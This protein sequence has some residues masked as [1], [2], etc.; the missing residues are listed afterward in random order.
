MGHS[1]RGYITFNRASNLSLKQRQ[2]SGCDLERYR[3]TFDR[4]PQR[5]IEHQRRLCAWLSSKNIR[6]HLWFEQ[7]LT[8]LIEPL[9]TSSITS[10]AI[11]ENSP[12]KSKL[13][14]AVSSCRKPSSPT[15]NR[16]ASEG[17]DAALLI[18]ST[19]LAFGTTPSLAASITP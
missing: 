3:F 14:S 7:V 8:R 10:L 11:S 16:G 9:E 18:S 4:F 13:G 5:S 19:S 1:W 2:V 17:A 15:L 12:S 6:S